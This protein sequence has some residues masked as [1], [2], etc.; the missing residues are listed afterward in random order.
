MAKRDAYFDNVKFILIVLVVFGH[1]LT[2][3]INDEQ[4]LRTLYIFIYTFHM[5][6]FILISGYF[7]KGY[8]KER[9]YVEDGEESIVSL[10]YLST[11]LCDI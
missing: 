5:P 6:A 7:A 1:L 8:R 11:Y 9:I 4:W 2:P 10:C 3:F